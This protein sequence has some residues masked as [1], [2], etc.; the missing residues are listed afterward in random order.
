[1][2]LCIFLLLSVII[3]GSCADHKPVVKESKFA[4]LVAQYKEINID[5]FRV[6][7]TSEILSDTFKFKGTLIDTIIVKQF[8]K[9]LL[10]NFQFDKEYYACFKFFIDSNRTGL[11]TRTPGEYTSSSIKLLV[12]DTQKDSIVN[13]SELA[14]NWNDAESDMIKTSWLFRNLDNQINNF[15]WQRDNFVEDTDDPNKNKLTTTDKFYL[16][17]VFTNEQY[18]IQKSPAYLPGLLK[19]FI[20]K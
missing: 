6:Y 5:T 17:N 9:Q 20:S 11:I 13:F 15:I 8:P 3:F 10:Y 12:F 2:R 4:V 1:M 7:S 14:D 16:T 18:P 19:Y